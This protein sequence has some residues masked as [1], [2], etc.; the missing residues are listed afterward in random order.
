MKRLGNHL[1]TV[2]RAG[3]TADRLRAA[4]ENWHTSKACVAAKWAG[5]RPEIELL[6]GRR[7]LS[8]SGAHAATPLLPIGTGT[9][10]GVIW[11]DL[12]ANGSWD[13]GDGRGAGWTVYL[14]LKNDGQLDPGD[15]TAVT[16]PIGWYT[17]AGVPAGTYTVRYLTPDSTWHPAPKQ[18]DH[19]TVT[20]SFGQIAS[21]QDLGVTQANGQITGRVTD[22]GGTTVLPIQYWGVY[23][24]T[25]NNGHIDPGEP[26][27][28]TDANGSFSFINLLPGTYTVRVDPLHGGWMAV[29]PFSGAITVTSDGRVASPPIVFGYRQ[30][31][32]PA[33]YQVNQLVDYFLIG[34]SSSNAADRFVSQTMLGNGW[35][36]FIQQSV[37]PDINWGVRRIELH[38]PFGVTSG[39]GYFSASQ[40]LEAQADG[41]TWLTDD[42]V[43]AWQPITQSGVEVVAYIG[44]P[45]YDPSLHALVWDPAA[46]NARF[47]ASIAPLVQAGMSIA[48]DY[49]QAFTPGDLYNQAL[50]RLKAEGVKVYLENRPAEG[51]PYNWQFPIIAMEPGWDGTNPY[52]DPAQDWA[53]KNSEL[54]GG[55]VVRLL[56]NLP[57]GG[58]W[59]DKSW[60]LSDLQSI[61]QDGDSA[62]ISISVLRNDGLAMDDLLTPLAIHS[63][64]P[65]NSFT[66]SP[67]QNASQGVNPTV[68]VRQMVLARVLANLSHLPISAS[69]ALRP[70]VTKL[71]G[72]LS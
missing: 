31:A 57:A 15:P 32:P 37:Q 44:N 50:D 18:P 26:W 55:S 38:N 61:F 30:A 7:L 51:L 12:N 64:V 39:T 68:D 16:T 23:L 29:S 17:F 19:L 34:W 40:F 8:A 63:A 24:D 47:D 59:S 67:A 43:Q 6:E 25:N 52:V 10:A 65:P 2:G 9:I 58:S 56:Q 72:V 60:L 5:R 1:T 71:S 66:L 54:G 62:G 49:G 13:S 69:S 27:T 33:H 4:R 53:A 3:R 42:F 36:A 41:L 22:V 35:G 20:L 21:D 11:T 28:S 14:D 46:W 48:F 45:D 70:A